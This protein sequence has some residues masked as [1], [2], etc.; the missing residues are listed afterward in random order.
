[1]VAADFLKES[2]SCDFYVE[3]HQGSYNC[4]ASLDVD[5]V[6]VS[7]LVRFTSVEFSQGNLVSDNRTHK[8][9]QG[10]LGPIKMN[11]EKKLFLVPASQYLF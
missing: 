9:D 11:E 1:M 6:F 10:Y 8:S 3:I 2:S 5:I 4:G 7:L